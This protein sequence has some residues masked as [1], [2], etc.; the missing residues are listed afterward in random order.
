[1]EPFK[2]LC[3]HFWSPSSDYL[4]NTKELSMG[5]ESE[6]WFDLESGFLFPLG[7]GD[8]GCWLK[9]TEILWG[10]S[11]LL[12]HWVKNLNRLSGEMRYLNVAVLLDVVSRIG[13]W[14]K[15]S[16]LNCE[17]YYRIRQ[18]EHQSGQINRGRVRSVVFN[19]IRSKVMV[20]INGCVCSV[21][22]VLWLIQTY[23]VKSYNILG[24]H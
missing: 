7:V 15:I 8:T 17:E 10:V 18:D 23:N 16:G 14:K 20:K 12:W 1:M 19:E 21:H 22:C 4:I 5:I 6:Q 2:F 13:C 11:V 3:T 24:L 9:W